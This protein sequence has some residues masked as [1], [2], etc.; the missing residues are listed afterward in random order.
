MHG[1]FDEDLCLECDVL[2]DSTSCR[3]VRSKYTKEFVA[4]LPALESELMELPAMFV[5]ASFT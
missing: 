2:H 4:S 5:I 1:T 3:F